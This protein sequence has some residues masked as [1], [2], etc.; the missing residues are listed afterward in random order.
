MICLKI[1][2]FASA[3]TAKN[4]IVVHNKAEMDASLKEYGVDG[5]QQLVK[6][7]AHYN[8]VT[9][10][11]LKRNKWELSNTIFEKTNYG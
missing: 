7:F 4:G 10:F 1:R 9:Q 11:S 8:D 5:I 3:I 6:N 2:T